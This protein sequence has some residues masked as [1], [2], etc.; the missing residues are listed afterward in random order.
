M[1]LW[2]ISQSVNSGYDTYDSAVVVADHDLAARLTHPSGNYTWST[3]TASDGSWTG[4]GAVNARGGHYSDCGT[5]AHPNDVT[6]TKL[7]PADDPTPRVV[8]ASFNAG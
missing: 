8:C 3:W 1:Y 6:A 5:W 4:W 7:G 2:L